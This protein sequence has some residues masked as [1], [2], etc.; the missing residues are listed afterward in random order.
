LLSAADLDPAFGGTGV[1]TNDLGTSASVVAVEPDGKVVLGGTA[2]GISPSIDGFGLVRYTSTGELDTSFN[3]TGRVKTDFGKIGSRLHGLALVPDGALPANGK[4]VAVGTTIVA[5][6]YDRRTGFT[7]DDTA[8]AIARY[9]ANGSLDPTF[10]D[11]TKKGAT[12]RTGTTVLDLTTGGDWADEADAV[13]VQPDGKIV[14]A[15]KAGS[16]QGSIT[17]FGVIRLNANGTLDTSFGT[18]GE[19]IVH[20]P[21]SSGNSGGDPT[22]VALDS[23]GRIVVTGSGY[24][25]GVVDRLI[26]ARLTVS[27]A[28]DS[29][30]DGDGLVVLP[31]PSTLAYWDGV[32]VG[33]QPSGQIVVSGLTM[34]VGG[35]QGNVIFLA[36]LNPD[37]GLDSNPTSGFGPDHAGF[38]VD[39]RVIGAGNPQGPVAVQP[40][41]GA[42]VVTGALPNGPSSFEVLRYTADGVADSTFGAGGIAIYDASVGVTGNAASVGLAPDGKIVVA[43]SSANRFAAIRLMGDAPPPAQVGVLGT[44]SSLNAGSSGAPLGVV[45]GSSLADDGSDPSVLKPISRPSV[46]WRARRPAGVLFSHSMNQGD[47]R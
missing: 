14:I 31:P 29:S 4:I 17:N 46:A 23:Q 6:N 5:Q 19:V 42:I 22:G 43:G 24:G 15:G 8:W 2:K 45:P 18:G 47:A 41:N 33:F 20:L 3:I 16:V 12:T 30:F 13:V 32:S 35:A 7:N 40:T 9:N 21:A 39:T 25:I 37:G 11:L 1:V 28:L 36:R 26:V 38:V 27:G 34:P 44:T 10:G